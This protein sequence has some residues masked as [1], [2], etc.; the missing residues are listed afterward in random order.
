M[1]YILDALKKSE[2]E[3]AQR[4]A[5]QTNRNVSNDIQAE[6]SSSSRRSNYANRTVG[7]GASTVGLAP[8]SAT[9]GSDRILPASKTADSNGLRWVMAVLVVLLILLVLLLWWERMPFSTSDSAAQNT[10][11]NLLEMTKRTSDKTGVTRSEAQL[12]LAPAPQLAEGRETKG[13][14]AEGAEAKE[15]VAQAKVKTTTADVQQSEISTPPLQALKSIPTL[16]ITGHTYS[17]VPDKRSVVMNDRLWREGEPIRDGII[18]KEIT[19][20]G[21]TLDVQGWPVVVGRSHGWQAR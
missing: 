4:D 12:T 2:A 5:D 14:E 1:S 6:S 17:S 19:R 13:K 10:Q 16:T 21:I 18:L 3:R 8:G 9:R 20:D 11:P 7:L 15:R